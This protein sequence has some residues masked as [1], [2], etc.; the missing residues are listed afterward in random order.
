[1]C[2]SQIIDMHLQADL[3]KM[4]N[5]QAMAVH[6]WFNQHREKNLHQKEYKISYN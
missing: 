4:H 5:L 3:N 1:M 6:I 2:T